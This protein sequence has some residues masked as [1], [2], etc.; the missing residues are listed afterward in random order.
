MEYNNQ[1][2]ER[3]KRDG[4]SDE[5]EL[6]ELEH[7]SHDSERVDHE[8]EASEVEDENNGDSEVEGVIFFEFVFYCCSIYLPAK[9]PLCVHQIL[10]LHLLFTTH[11]HTLE[12]YGFRLYLNPPLRQKTILCFFLPML[13]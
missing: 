4:E 12:K 13:S 7:D 8:K 6:D 1:G 3:A 11:H 5:E 9:V 10:H 2:L